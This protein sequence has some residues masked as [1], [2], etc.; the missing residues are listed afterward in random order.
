MNKS[1]NIFMDLYNANH[2]ATSKDPKI[3]SIPDPL[4][5]A[6]HY[7]RFGIIFSTLT[8]RLLLG[9]DVKLLIILF[10]SF[11]I[12]MSSRKSRT[13]APLNVNTI[14]SPSSSSRSAPPSALAS[15]PP[16]PSPASS[17]S[18]SPSSNSE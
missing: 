4:P 11:L 3:R 2:K 18:P 9:E 13:G 17:P 8:V 16:S 15:A 14:T 10:F 1:V 5:Y 6:Q 7:L 12:K